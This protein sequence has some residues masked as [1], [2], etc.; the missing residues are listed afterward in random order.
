[1]Q[2]RPVILRSLLIVATPYTQRDLLQC[3]V[4]WCSVLQC[5]AVRCSVLQLSEERSLHGSMLQCVAMCCSVVQCVPA[6]CS[7]LHFVALFGN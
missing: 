7:V 1:M 4:V 6:S 2:K 3:V 5:V